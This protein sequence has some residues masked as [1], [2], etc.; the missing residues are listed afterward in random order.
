M[1]V[2][3]LW[4]P[5]PII[6][7][8]RL[9]GSSWNWLF[10]ALS[11]FGTAKAV[12]VMFALALWV[13]GRQLAYGLL[14]VVL[15]GTVIDVL[16]WT[17][18]PVPRPH[19]PQIIIRTHPGVPSF[20]SGHT[21]TA[22][23]LWGTLTA[24]GRLPAVISVCIVLLVMLSRLYLGV[25]YLADLLGGAAIALILVVAYQRFWPMLVRWFSGR[26]FQFF[27]VLGLSAPI[28]VFP[29]TSFSPR[30]WELFGYAVGLGIGMPLEYWYVRYSPAKISRRKQVL[31][32]AIG[33]GGLVT[34]VLV[35][36]LMISSG[37][38]REAVT[39][40]FA[41]LW[42]AFL[43]PALFASMGLSRHLPRTR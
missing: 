27:L 20:P 18:F 7:I 14:G 23:T 22:T 6:T 28:A 17:I 30:G 5:E 19:D 2:D 3:I 11:Q 15:L 37:L 42:I 33:L 10:E 40:G 25:H 38:V 39:S 34:L 24:F 9:F 4:S 32:V 1:A 26:T 36:R 31:K 12:T 43:A 41:A 29:F 8:Q 13:W 16:I 35:F 21:V